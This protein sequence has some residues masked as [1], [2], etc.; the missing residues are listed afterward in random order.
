M[1]ASSRQ[2]QWGTWHNLLCHYLTGAF[3]GKAY[4]RQKVIYQGHMQGLGNTKVQNLSLLRGFRACQHEM[5]S[6]SFPF[7]SPVIFSLGILFFVSL[8]AAPSLSFPLICLPSTLNYF[9]S[10][11]FSV[12]YSLFSLILCNHCLS[13]S[14][15]LLACI[16]CNGVLNTI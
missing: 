10:F 11:L 5:I 7:V 15:R 2:T 4:M 12:L 1:H 13:P 16:S 3:R 9:C 8:L 6:L 14:V